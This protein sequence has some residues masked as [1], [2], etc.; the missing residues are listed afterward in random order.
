MHGAGQ[1]LGWHSSMMTEIAGCWTHHG[2]TG[3]VGRLLQLNVVADHGVGADPQ[4]H[5]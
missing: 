4:R 3:S 5:R 2:E 1:G